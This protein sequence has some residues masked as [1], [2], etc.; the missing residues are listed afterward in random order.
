MIKARK[1][2]TML[3]GTIIMVTVFQGLTLQTVAPKWL[4]EYFYLIGGGLIFFCGVVIGQE[5]EEIEKAFLA[6]I[7]LI[8]YVVI[9]GIAF[10]Y[11]PVLYGLHF[12]KGNLTAFLLSRGIMAALLWF[13]LGMAGVFTGASLKRGG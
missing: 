10:N 13:A 4:I 8:S 11:L 3:S 1:I 9:L 2:I 5:W 12:V 6:M 7:R